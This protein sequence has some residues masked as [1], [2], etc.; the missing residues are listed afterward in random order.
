[1]TNTDINNLIS[2]NKSIF[3]HGSTVS[4]SLLCNWFSLA[5]PVKTSSVSIEEHEV[6]TLRFSA[7]RQA[8]QSKLNRLLAHRG[9]HLAQVNYGDHYKMVDK[10]QIPNVVKTYRSRGRACLA[11]A[12]IIENSSNTYD[13]WSK[14]SKAEI[15]K[16]STR[17]RSNVNYI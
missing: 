1:M 9:L 12:Q 3:T 17:S 6:A 8:A 2:K 16:V 11:K 14:L 4:T 10:K 7:K 15:V 5:K 13:R